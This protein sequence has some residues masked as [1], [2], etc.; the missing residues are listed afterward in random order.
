MNTQLSTYS[1]VSSKK[2]KSSEHLRILKRALHI[3][4]SLQPILYAA[5]FRSPS[6]PSSLRIPMY[7][8]IF[9]FFSEYLRILKRALYIRISLQPILYAAL[10]RCP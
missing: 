3:R 1:N 10:Y 4:I 7:P 9:Y 5:L 2:R 6:I 8:Q